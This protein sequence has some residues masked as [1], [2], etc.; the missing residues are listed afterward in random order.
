MDQAETHVWIA[1]V[2]EDAAAHALAGLLDHQER[3]QAARLIAEDLRARFVFRRALLR[4]VLAEHVGIQAADLRFR[5]EASGKP[6]LADAD[7]PSFN[8]SHTGDVA[9][10]AV[11]D[12]GPVGIDVEIR[13]PL[14]DAEVMARRFFTEAEVRTLAA[15]HEADRALLFLRAWIRKEAFL[16]ATGEGIG[17]GL[18]RVE[19]TCAAGDPP[20]I[21]SV[22]GDPAA[23]AAWR[24]D[25]LDPYPDVVGAL[26][27]VSGDG[28]IRMRPAAPLLEAG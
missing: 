22:G 1:R 5:Q 10:V 25:D 2:G 20:R 23:A 17:T 7:G 3:E 9:V 16:K 19:V 6:V 11:G 12:G 13:R 15:A 8:M 18:D 24:L 4:L 21:L 14:P 27:R 26:V 28:P